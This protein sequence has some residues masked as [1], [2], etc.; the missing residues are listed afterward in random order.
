MA[1][2][3]SFVTTP[4]APFLKDVHTIEADNL[5]QIKEELSSDKGVAVAALPCKH[6]LKGFIWS[7][8]TQKLSQTKSMGVLH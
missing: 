2:S 5:P 6:A 7:N 4:Y 3:P 1:V 8:K